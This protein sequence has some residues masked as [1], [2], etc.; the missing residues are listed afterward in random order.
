MFGTCRFFCRKVC[1][2]R[3]YRCVNYP[4]PATQILFSFPIFSIPAVLAFLDVSRHPKAIIKSD[5]APF[6]HAG[7]TPSCA[8]VSKGRYFVSLQFIG[9]MLSLGVDTQRNGAIFILFT[10]R[11]QWEKMPIA[12]SV[13]ITTQCLFSMSHL[14]NQ[15]LDHW[16]LRSPKISFPALFAGRLLLYAGFCSSVR[17][18]RMRMPK[19]TFALVY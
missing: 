14:S 7:S 19:N 4:P 9:S 18:I 3:L 12:R 15:L 6:F 2:V 10:L 1:G 17:S 5:H 11:Q 8:W 13:S 16:D